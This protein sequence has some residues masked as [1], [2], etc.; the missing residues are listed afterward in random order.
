M[1]DVLIKA[2]FIYLRWFRNS[3]H[4]PRATATAAAAAATATAIVIA[5][6]VIRSR[7]I[8]G[9]TFTATVAVPYAM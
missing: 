5:G 3:M 9:R 4:L 1:N 8:T 7:N 6:V 2:A